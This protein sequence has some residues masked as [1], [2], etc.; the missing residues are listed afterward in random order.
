[1]LCISK[2]QLTKNARTEIVQSVTHKMLNYC[3]YPSKDQRE[4][5][6]SKIVRTI[7]GSRDALGVGHVSSI[8]V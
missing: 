8:L 5:V 1:M 2:G 3:K 7:N 4:I 6:A